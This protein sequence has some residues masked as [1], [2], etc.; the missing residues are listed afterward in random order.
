[1][2]YTDHVL[3]DLYTLET[4]C[5]TKLWD[6]TRHVEQQNQAEAAANNEVEQQQ[7]DQQEMHSL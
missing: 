5:I 7:V 1:M 3:F 6:F 4:S 2:M